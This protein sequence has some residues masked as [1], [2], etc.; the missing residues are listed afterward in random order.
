M[1]SDDEGFSPGDRGQLLTTYPGWGEQ[2]WNVHVIS[3]VVPLVGGGDIIRLAIGDSPLETDPQRMAHQVAIPETDVDDSFR[4]GLTY[5]SPR[6]AP[7]PR[8]SPAHDGPH[9]F[10]PSARAYPSGAAARP[11]QD[12][13]SPS[14]TPAAK[15]QSKLSAR[16]NAY[17]GATARRRAAARRAAAK[18]ALAASSTKSPATPWHRLFFGLRRSGGSDDD[19]G[20]LFW[21]VQ[22]Y[23]HDCGKLLR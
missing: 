13:G 1:S 22:V 23:G 16:R 15:R 14:G 11:P 19:M 17:L 3:T 12:P 8:P 9:A 20:H 18:A 2:W 21:A 5:P 6:P 7:A 10:P 4:P